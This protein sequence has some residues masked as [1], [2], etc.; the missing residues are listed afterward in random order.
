MVER[1]VACRDA[2]LGPA[3]AGVDP[4]P[5]RVEAVR[6]PGDGV[7][8]VPALRPRLGELGESA[9]RRRGR[10]GAGEDQRAE[11]ARQRPAHDVERAGVVGAQDGR[12]DR[13]QVVLEPAAEGIVAREERGDGC[14]AGHLV[15]TR[16]ER[17]GHAITQIARR[18]VGRLRGRQSGAARCGRRCGRPSREGAGEGR[19]E[20]HRGTRHPAAG[21]RG[22]ASGPRGW[23][24]QGDLLVHADVPGWGRRGRRSDQS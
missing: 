7:G 19:E 14:A 13:G 15:P 21:P 6:R 20:Q 18:G 2:G 11:V 16:G 4:R 24:Q 9:V 12:V 1:V 17:H 23:A 5:Q 3:V 10:R 22:D 8:V